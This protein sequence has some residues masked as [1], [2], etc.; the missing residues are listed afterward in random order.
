MLSHKCLLTEMKRCYD[1]AVRKPQTLLVA[2]CL[3]ITTQ[4][5]SEARGEDHCSRYRYNNALTTD[6]MQF[7]KEIPDLEYG[8]LGQF[9]SLHCCAKGYRSIE[10]FKNG[11]PYPWGGDISSLIVYPEAAN[12]TIYTHRVAEADIGNYSCVLRNDTS[13][14]RHDIELRMQEDKPDF[15]LPTFRP[16]DLIISLGETARFYCEAFVG[17]LDLP[18]AT[19]KVV[20]MQMLD[21]KPASVLDANQLNVTREDGQII[22]SYLSIPR[23][24]QHHYGRYRCQITSGNLA[25]P[26]E[27]SVSLSPAQVTAVEESEFEFLALIIIVSIASLLAIMLFV[28]CKLDQRKGHSENR[29]SAQFIADNEN[30]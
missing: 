26:L 18:D 7:T 21:D 20:W 8:I 1:V 22:G 9:K 30:M 16:K 15:P 19:N 3:M 23:I 10:W 28:L 27:L 17:K 25:R 11:Q 14:I 29:C 2:I 24:Q 6:H 12:Q 4:L 13:I 5:F